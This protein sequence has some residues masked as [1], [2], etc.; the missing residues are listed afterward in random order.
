MRCI[1]AF[2]DVIRPEYSKRRTRAESDRYPSGRRLTT[3]YGE[4]IRLFDAGDLE[5]AL[6]KFRKALGVSIRNTHLRW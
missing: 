5:G 3:L 6:L 4:G 1:L 2:A